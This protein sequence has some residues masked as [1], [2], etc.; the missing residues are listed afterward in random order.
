MLSTVNK[1]IVNYML[2]R[3][4]QRYSENHLFIHS[5]CFKRG[6]ILNYKINGAKVA[7]ELKWIVVH[8]GMCSLRIFPRK[9]GGKSSF[10]ARAQVHAIFFAPTEHF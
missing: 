4:N 8:I 1:D 7:F 6:Q 9:G 3:F 5:E 2:P 10:L